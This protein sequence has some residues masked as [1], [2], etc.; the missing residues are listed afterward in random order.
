[1][2][3]TGE[4][5]VIHV[6]GDVAENLQRMVRAEIRLAKA[7]AKEEL[8]VFVRGAILCGIA[9][10]AALFGIMYVLLAAVYTL[11]LWWPLWAA[12]LV[13]GIVM[14]IF[15]AIGAAIGLKRFQVPTLTRTSQ[16]LKENVPWTR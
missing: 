3:N 5:S 6:L 13:V 7:E 15:A 8:A 2:A 14:L 10:V 1:M 11:A 16:S 4:R 9:A 12:A